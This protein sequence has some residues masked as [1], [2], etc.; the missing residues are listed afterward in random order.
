M[1]ILKS[2]GRFI[3]KRSS[4]ARSARF[5]LAMLPVVAMGSRLRTRR[6]W[7]EHEE[8]QWLMKELHGLLSVGYYVDVGA[9]HPAANSNTYRLYNFGMRGI[10]VEPNVALCT[11]HRR[12][13]RGDVVINAAVGS[14]NTAAKFWEMRAHGI[15]T[16]SESEALAHQAAGCDIM[17]VMITPVLRLDTILR[18]YSPGQTP[19]QLLSVDMEGMDEIVLQS[20]DWNH[21]RPRLVIAEGNSED[22]AQAVA[23][24]MNSVG[25]EAAAKFAVN[26]IYRDASKS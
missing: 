9:N 26:T 20:N 16:L 10:I 3:L 14:E 15:S 1:G 22:A 12:Y 2:G 17:Q 13:R 24:F 19:F 21:F 25:Y 7:S 5:N 23:A 8:D 18:A 11:L 4:L 6:V